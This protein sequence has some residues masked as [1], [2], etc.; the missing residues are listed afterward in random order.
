MS[1]PNHQPKKANIQANT[2]W[3]SY[4]EFDNHEFV[5]ALSDEQSGLKAFVAVHNTNRGPALGGTR[6]KVYTSEEAALED[7]L[8]L[9]KAMSYKCALA[10]LPYGGGKAVIMADNK[11]NRKQ[12][13]TAYA[14]LVEK[15]HGLF[16]T[17]TDVGISDE[18]VV[19][20]AAATKH[21]LGVVAAERGDLNTSKVAAL[22]VFHGIKAALRQLHGTADFSGRAVAIKGAGKLGGELAR[23]IIAA[24][25]QVLVS[26][27][28]QE[29]CR[30]LKEQW[31][32]IEIVDNDTIHA[33]KVDIYAPCAL[34]NEFNTTTI[35]KLR[36]DAVVGGANNQ[37]ENI[38]AGD[39]LHERSILYAPDY[40]ANAGG[41]IYVADELEPGGFSKERV[42]VR[43]AAIEETLGLIFEEA[44]QQGLPSH[45]VADRLALERM[46][47]ANRD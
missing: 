21:M 35:P 37:L 24:G 12:V 4:P 33:Q 23:M 7:V 20:M 36:C 27:V 18:D 43:T 31:P 8:N 16:K 1:K 30:V 5:M 22:G 47:G 14:Q 44:K 13:L 40:I 34:G 6:M 42:L 41:L 38:A 46:H 25:G 29:A 15:L 28:N 26:D 2:S 32:A 19:H 39:L 17:G 45:V 3:R 10:N 9:S 11:L